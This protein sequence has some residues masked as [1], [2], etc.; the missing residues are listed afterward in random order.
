MSAETSP[1]T[2]VTRIEAVTMTV[3]TGF[4]AEQAV[5]ALAGPPAQSSMLPFDAAEDMGWSTPGNVPV[6]FDVCPGGAVVIEPNGFIMSIPGY[7]V[8]MTAGGGRLVSE[9]WCNAI[10]KDF[11]VFARD[12]ALERSFHAHAHS[13]GFGQPQDEEAGLPWDTAPKEAMSALFERVAMVP[14]TEQWLLETSRTSWAIAE[15]PDPA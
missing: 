1:L 11:V 2:W 8:P 3:L 13:A 6:Q 12:G 7:V 9:Y 15:P 5:R 10:G 4:S 14:L